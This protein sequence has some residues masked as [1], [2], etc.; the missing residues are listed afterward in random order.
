M[1][2]GFA[3][4]SL[5]L[6]VVGDELGRRPHTV[7][8]PEIGR[9]PNPSP[10]GERGGNSNEGAEVPRGQPMTS[11]QRNRSL[12]VSQ[13]FPSSSPKRSLPSRVQF[14]HFPG[15]KTRNQSF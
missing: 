12:I 14:R 6:W 5:R 1:L 11:K 10:A 3:T 7:Q 4:G 2:G 15:C 8:G 13:K 9:R